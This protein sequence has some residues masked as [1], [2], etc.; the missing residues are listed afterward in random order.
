MHSRASDTRKYIYRLYTEVKVSTR[1]IK[2]RAEGKRYDKSSRDRTEVR[3]ITHFFHSIATHF[4][5][6]RNTVTK[7]IFVRGNSIHNFTNLWI[8][9]GFLWLFR[10]VTDQQSIANDKKSFTSCRLPPPPQPLLQ[11]KVWSSNSIRSI[12][13]AI[14]KI[15]MQE[16]PHPTLLESHTRGIN[17]T[18]ITSIQTGVVR[19]S[20]RTNITMN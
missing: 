5:R 8:Y 19:F 7:Q 3:C 9:C 6:V 14:K 20:K 2:P 13:I 10:Q 4:I 18:S 16:Q 15:G 1:F 17:R 12:A 11:Y